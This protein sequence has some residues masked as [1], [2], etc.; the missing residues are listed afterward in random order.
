MEIF[1]RGLSI[2]VWDVR[3]G[4]RVSTAGHWV[5]RQVQDNNLFSTFCWIPL[6][7]SFFNS[8]F[9]CSH[10]Q[11][12]KAKVDRKPDMQDKVIKTL[13]TQVMLRIMSCIQIA[14]K[15][16]SSKRVIIC[17]L[18]S[19]CDEREKKSKLY[20]TNK[21]FLFE[22]FEERVYSPVSGRYGLQVQI[23]GGVEL[24]APSSNR[25]QFRD[26]LDNAVRFHGALARDLGQRGERAAHEGF[27]PDWCQ[28]AVQV[29]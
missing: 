14:N 10:V 13:Q 9:M 5:V 7:A 27:L 20:M 19:R 18:F 24:G 17:K 26:Q 11:G 22:A 25:T 12:L 15:L 16:I 1:P 29:L 21:I 3:A 4:R 2:S 8:R 23:R 6:N 28:Y